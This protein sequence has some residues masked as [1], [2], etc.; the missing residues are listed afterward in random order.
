MQGEAAQQDTHSKQGYQPM[1]PS[2]DPHPSKP[3]PQSSNDNPCE[4]EVGS[5]IQFGNP[6]CYGVIKW[7][8]I[9]PETEHVLMAGVELVSC[10]YSR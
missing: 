2:P 8:G 4:L 7:M 3:D 10:T 6:P 1:W 5:M 9:L